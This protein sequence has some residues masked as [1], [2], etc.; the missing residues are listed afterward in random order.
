M[1][2]VRNTVKRNLLKGLSEEQIAKVKACK[3]HEDLLTLAKNEG[4]ELTEEQLEAVSGGCGTYT[5]RCPKC[6]SNIIVE[7]CD[8]KKDYYC[9]NCGHEFNDNLWED[10]KNFVD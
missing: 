6:G 10:I 2:R 8:G 7:N 3:S 1:E 9:N 4:V 5:V